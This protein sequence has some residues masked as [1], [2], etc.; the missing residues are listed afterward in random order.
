MR[1]F[2]LYVALLVLVSLLTA[3]YWLLPA[4]LALG[5]LGVLL[6]SR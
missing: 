1:L 5:G 3:Q 4:G 6:T 2:G